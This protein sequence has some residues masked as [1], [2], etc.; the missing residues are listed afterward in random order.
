ML[1]DVMGRSGREAVLRR[2]PELRK[3]LSLDFVVVNVDNAAHGFGITPD[4]ARQFFEAGAD[5]LTGGNHLFDQREIIGFLE[6]ERRL[7]RP[8]NMSSSVPGK[9]MVEIT[10]ANGRKAVVIHLI[11]Q[12]NMPMAGDSP[13]RLTDCLLSEY[14]LGENV[15]AVIVDFHAE[16]TSEKNALG[17][18]SD[19]RVSAVIGTHTHIPTADERI[20]ERGTAFQ[21]DVGM[22]GDY[23]SIIGMHKSAVE[24]FAKGYK[25]G[26]LFPASGAAILCGAL[27]DVDDKT[28]LASS[29]VRIKIDEASNDS[30]V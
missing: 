3:R 8:A 30:T 26:R 2:L 16:M 23:D 6:T 10:A 15:S 27:V 25:C 11:G 1:G 13:F 28:G 4:M 19:G 22:C 7:L 21:T 18:Y 5:V 29:I 9:G 12:L 17:R 24:R 14:K 20:L